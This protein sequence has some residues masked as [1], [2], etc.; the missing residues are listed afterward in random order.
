MACVPFWSGNWIAGRRDDCAARRDVYGEEIKVAV[1][2]NVA[3]RHAATPKRVARSDP[4]PERSATSIG[5]RV[6]QRHA[7]KRG[8]SEGYVARMVKWDREGSRAGCDVV[9]SDRV[10]PTPQVCSAATEREDPASGLE[11]KSDIIETKDTPEGGSDLKVRETMFEESR[12]LHAPVLVRSV[13]T[14]KMHKRLWVSDAHPDRTSSYLVDLCIGPSTT[15]PEQCCECVSV[16]DEGSTVTLC[17]FLTAVQF[18]PYGA[19]WEVRPT[20][21]KQAMGDSKYAP[22]W[23]TVPVTL[24]KHVGVDVIGPAASETKKLRMLVVV[25]ED[26]SRRLLLG[27]D[28]SVLFGLHKRRAVEWNI[29]AAALRDAIT[30]QRGAGERV[31]RAAARLGKSPRK[32]LHPASPVKTSKKKNGGRE[33]GTGSRAGV[34]LWRDMKREAAERRRLVCNDDATSA[35]S[36]NEEGELFEEADSPDTAAVEA[37][38]KPDEVVVQMTTVRDRTTGSI[39]ATPGENV[40]AARF[41]GNVL[42][43]E[44]AAEVVQ[45][46]TA[47]ERARPA[48]GHQEEGTTETKSSNSVVTPAVATAAGGR[49]GETTSGEDTVRHEEDQKHEDDQGDG[50]GAAGDSDEG[51]IVT[52]RPETQVLGMICADGRSVRT[53]KIGTAGV[54]VNPSIYSVHIEEYFRDFLKPCTDAD[55]TAN[56]GSRPMGTALQQQQQVAKARWLWMHM[57]LPLLVRVWLSRVT[58]NLASV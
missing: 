10:H 15:D 11:A 20:R 12:N 22:G 58:V 46:R 3:A 13:V 1:G 39:A 40:F 35:E 57:H 8:A 31:V 16:S 47:R 53:I 45:P 56:A 48:D 43:S 17:D 24:R 52:T 19:K 33:R 29:P 7:E 21:L 30:A 4:N 50:S 37:R 36:K 27:R 18:F 54:A 44:P 25:L 38:N 14:G 23:V 26:N 55:G 42:E 34:K 6:H 2:R 49:R 5:A 51:H 32:R 28:A 9:V 41:A